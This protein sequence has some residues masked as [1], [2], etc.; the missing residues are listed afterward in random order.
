MRSGPGF[1][2]AGCVHDAGVY[3]SDEEFLALSVPFV[4]EGVAAGEPV[5]VGYDA[6]KTQLLRTALVEP[7]GVTFLTDGEL[8][9]K[10]ATAIA[11]YRR[12]FEQAVAEG[13]GQVR[14]AGDVPHPGNGGDFADWDR[15]ESA[16]NDVWD[17]LPVYALCLYSATATPP[18]VLDVVHRTHR[19]LVDTGGRRPNL[20][21]EDVASFRPLPIQP[22]PV[23]TTPP[24]VKFIAATASSARRQVRE[25]VAGHAAGDVDD[26][27]LAV[28]EAVTNGHLHGIA[29]VTVRVWCT[30]DRLVVSVHDC[31]QG[32]SSPLAGLSPARPIDAGAGGLGLWLV[33]Q[34]N[35]DTAMTRDATGFTI[36][37]RTRPPHAR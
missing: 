36:R 15:Y 28:S 5:V 32:P 14:I 35:H 31:G 7:D 29:P 30:A 10:P 25:A 2:Q 16:M 4:E 11:S 27:V 13:A 21:F 26:L 22:D 17:A 20:R 33:H 34:M 9:A 24:T 37:F 23:E 12:M 3:R 19:H 8:Y 18:G 1:G 6:R